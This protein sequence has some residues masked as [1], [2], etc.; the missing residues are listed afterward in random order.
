MNKK[1]SNSV[2]DFLLI[3]C[4]SGSVAYIVSLFVIRFFV[5]GGF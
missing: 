3:L 5:N 2:I 4:L 1:V